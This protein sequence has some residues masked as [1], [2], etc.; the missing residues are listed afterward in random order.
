MRWV[1]TITASTFLV[2]G[3]ASNG[4]PE[5]KGKEATL[6]IRETAYTPHSDTVEI[7]ESR[8]FVVMAVGSQSGQDVVTHD[9]SG[10]AE[11]SQEDS[12]KDDHQKDDHQKDDDQAPPNEEQSS[13]EDDEDVTE[14]SGSSAAEFSEL[15]LRSWSAYCYSG[16]GMTNEMW[17]VIEDANEEAPAWVQD[18]GPEVPEPERTRLQNCPPGLLE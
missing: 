6:E 4:D 8:G 18:P 16:K 5:P 11:E 3:C 12:Q 7:P 2:T 14:E 17:N 10:S 15:E 9:F 13:V 1:I